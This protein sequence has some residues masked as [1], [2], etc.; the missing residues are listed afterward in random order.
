M[1][2]EVLTQQALQHILTWLEHAEGEIPLVLQ[3][4]LIWGLWS[5]IGGIFVSLF[6]FSLAAISGSILY[7][8]KENI[9]EHEWLII[10]LIGVVLFPIIGVSVLCVNIYTTLFILIAPKVYLLDKIL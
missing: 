8:Y 6:L 9:F 7:E 1:E 3:E 5:A 2:T 4:T 10:P